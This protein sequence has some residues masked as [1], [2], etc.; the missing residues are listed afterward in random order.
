MAGCLNLWLQHE[1]IHNPPKSKEKRQRACRNMNFFAALKGSW[2]VYKIWVT[3]GWP[4]VESSSLIKSLPQSW[5]VMLKLGPPKHKEELLRAVLETG[6]S[7]LLGWSDL[8]PCTR[9]GVTKSWPT[10]ESA[11]PIKSLPQSWSVM[12]RL[13][14]PKN[15][16]KCVKVVLETGLTYCVEQILNCAQEMGN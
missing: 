12:L 3:N 11:S 9:D 1:T 7:S 8:E 4:A 2:T 5:S 13:G 10:M 15:K 6:L 16:E 14:P